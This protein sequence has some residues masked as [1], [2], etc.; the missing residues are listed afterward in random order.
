MTSVVPHPSNAIKPND[1]NDLDIIA[2]VTLLRPHVN[3]SNA[4]SGG[5][6]SDEMGSFGPIALYAAGTGEVRFRD[7]SYKDINLK[8]FP[9]E[10]VSANFR[11]QRLTPFQYSWAQAA[12]DVNHDGN[13]DIIIPP[14]IFIGPDYTTAREFYAAETLNPSTVYP[15]HHGRLRRR[16]HR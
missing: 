4:S 15:V 6:V 13:L 16:L 10:Q 7:V 5:A 12:A 8:R 14:F 3:S 2:D 11:M 1:W 9:K